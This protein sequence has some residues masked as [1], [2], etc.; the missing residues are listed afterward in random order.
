M[1]EL[2]LNTPR[3]NKLVE[4]KTLIPTQFHSNVPIRV[5]DSLE[6]T[7]IRVPHRDELTDTHAFRINGPEKSLPIFQIMIHGKKPWTWYNKEV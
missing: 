3:W 2:I 7:P 6:I 1:I 5:S 4:E